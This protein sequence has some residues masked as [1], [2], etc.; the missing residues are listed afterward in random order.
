[1]AT[2]PPPPPGLSGDLL[3]IHR[4]LQSPA[5]IQRRLRTIQDLRF[6]S[7]QILTQRYRSSGGAVLYEVSEP[8]FT[9]RPIEAVPAG[10]EYPKDV[11]PE[12]AAALAAVTKWG[13]AT[14]LTD[15]K[16]KRNARPGNELDRVLRKVV[17]TVIKHI[18]TITMSAVASAVTQ[19]QAA[20]AA[21]N[22][23]A[24]ILRDVELAI[25]KVEDLQ[26]GYRPNII[27]MSN[28]KYAY[29]ASDEK[30][31]SLRRRET[32]DNP[33]YNGSV[34]ILADLIVVKAPLSVLPSDDVW[35]IDS[36]QLG[37]MADEAE[38]DP[39]YTVDELAVQVQSER[40]P[41]RDMWEVWGRRITV[42]VVQEPG[43][44][45]K[46]TGT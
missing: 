46:I 8:I 5:Q 6:I 4:L 16:I 26:M 18:D 19:T 37:G 23:T 20:S 44:G 39:G 43:S 11:T 41:R 3:T 45:I 35:V 32:T 33:V 12:G 21:W 7:D 14:Q 13:Q 25:A 40:L 36:M 30:L 15:E 34:D 2:Y 38:V 1:M 42:P 9:T 22:S 29:M 28:T 27:V 24:T 17:N 10:A 31:A